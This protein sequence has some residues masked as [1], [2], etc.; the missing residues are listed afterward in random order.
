MIF[1]RFKLSQE[2]FDTTQI[3]KYWG[4]VQGQLWRNGWRLKET[5]ENIGSKMIDLCHTKRD[6]KSLQQILQIFFFNVDRLRTL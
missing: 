4:I 6:R 2:M 3:M 1:C 5:L